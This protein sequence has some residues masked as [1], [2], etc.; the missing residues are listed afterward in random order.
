LFYLLGWRFDL[1]VCFMELELEFEFGFESGVEFEF[2]FFLEDGLW[3]CVRG[4]LDMIWDGMGWDGMGL[5]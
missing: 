1:I 4:C 2:V 5:F 3:G